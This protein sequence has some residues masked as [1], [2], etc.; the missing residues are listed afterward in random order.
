[1]YEPTSVEQVTPGAALNP[2]FGTTVPPTL[3]LIIPW[4]LISMFAIADVVARFPPATELKI[5]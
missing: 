4:N 1:M 2:L 3:T 5:A